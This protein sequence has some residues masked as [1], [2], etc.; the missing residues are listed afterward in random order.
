MVFKD[1]NIIRKN[2]ELS[3][4]MKDWEE[5][6]QFPNEMG[7]S[8]HIQVNKEQENER[9]TID[10]KKTREKVKMKENNI[11]QNLSFS[12]RQIAEIQRLQRLEEKNKDFQIIN[13]L[14]F[15]IIDYIH[16]YTGFF[17]SS[18]RERKKMIIKKGSNIIST[19]LDIKYII[20]KFYEIE[21]LKQILLSEEDIEEF[22]H[23]PKPKMRVIV[24]SKNK[25]D[26]GIIVTE[27]FSKQTKAM[28]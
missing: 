22:A 10:L 5:K 3:V 25:R 21:K 6:Q 8:V 23:L 9:N 4:K 20:Q 13:D 15:G 14:K 16:Y 19:C 2:I 11:P 24:D 17:K 12:T 7:K 18:E 27:I 1:E 28:I 26:K